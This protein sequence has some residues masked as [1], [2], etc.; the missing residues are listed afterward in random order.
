MN[1]AAIL[2]AVQAGATAVKL[3]VD[4]ARQA[5][6]EGGITA[7]EFEAIQAAALSA[8]GRWDAAIEAALARMGKPQPGQ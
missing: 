4:L 1:A 2:A 5:R 8:D 3:V 7:Q 6:D